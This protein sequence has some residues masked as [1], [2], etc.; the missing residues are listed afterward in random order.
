MSTLW[1]TSRQLNLIAAA[2]RGRGQD[3]QVALAQW[4]HL[5]IED[6]QFW[7]EDIRA[8]LRTADIEIESAGP[9]QKELRDIDDEV[10]YERTRDA[11]G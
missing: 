4:T 2:V 1:I 11:T 9:T 7:R 8:A 6:K 10:R 3:S 5:P